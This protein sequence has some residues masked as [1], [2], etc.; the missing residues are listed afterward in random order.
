MDELP[1][2]LLPIKFK[3]RAVAPHK[4]IISPV[5]GSRNVL[6]NSPWTYVALWLKRSG[7]DRALFYWQ[8]AQEFH[9]ASLGLPPQSAPLLLYYAFLN[10]TKALLSAKGIIFNER[11]G[12]SEHSNTSQG[13]AALNHL[14][15]RIQPH[16]VLPSLSAYYG[17]TES[18]RTH[19]L[20]A[21]FFNMVFIHRTYCLTYTSQP[22]M[23]IPIAN[24]AF[25]AEK[26]TK[27]IYFRA[28]VTKNMSF[29]RAARRLPVQFAA[30]RKFG[31][32]AIRSTDY[33]TSRKPGRISQTDLNQ[34]TVL[35]ARLRREL[36][37]INGSEPLWYIKSRTRGPARIER[38]LPT[39]I[40][41]AMHRLS[42]ISRY[43]PPQMAS[44]LAGQKN[45]LLTEFIRMSADQFIDEIASELTGFQFLIPNIRAAA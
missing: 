17:E 42:E 34:I 30:D 22:E 37:F 23:F 32:R 11:H 39:L 43:N 20:Q 18:G 3:G 27:Q 9:K 8:Q 38:Q 44:L 45:W 7:K 35:N 16:G 26:S 40:L 5:I 2:G 25:V 6:T 28:D 24:C 36:F 29:D 19:T 13:G 10:A 15:I 33:V 1:K 21:L 41:G 4:A 12:V 14:G 31:P